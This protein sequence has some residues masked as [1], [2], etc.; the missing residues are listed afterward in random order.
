[1]KIHIEESRATTKA[2]LR[3]GKIYMSILKTKWN[4]KIWPWGY[5]AEWDKSDKDTNTVRYVES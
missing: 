3:R 5:Y 1:M 2:I 4:Q